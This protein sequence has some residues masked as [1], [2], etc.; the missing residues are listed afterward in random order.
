MIPSLYETTPLT[1]LESWAMQ[2]PVIITRVGILRSPKDDNTALLVKTCNERSLASAMKTLIS[3][4]QTR[5]S[6][7]T[8]AYKKAQHYTWEKI[9]NTLQTIYSEGLA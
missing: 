5:N 7:K 6:L 8:S 3:N 1:L 2:I 9:Y 4:A